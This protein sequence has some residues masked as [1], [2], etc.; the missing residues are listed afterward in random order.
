MSVTRDFTSVSF[1]RSEKKIKL[2]SD[3]GDSG[4]KN[5]KRGFRSACGEVWRNMRLVGV[6][7]QGVGFVLVRLARIWLSRR[8]DSIIFNIL[9]KTYYKF[10]TFNAI[11]KDNAAVN[12]I[13]SRHKKGSFPSTFT[14][15]RAL[16]MI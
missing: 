2:S 12:F 7:R 15:N 9:K 1:V 3:G 14:G 10:C 8:E 13:T 6:W 16:V 4:N 11:C 5:C